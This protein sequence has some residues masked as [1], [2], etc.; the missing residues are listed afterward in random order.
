MTL[1][2]ALCI[3][4]GVTA[5]VGGG[6][7]TT[8]LRALGEELS[9]A[10]HTVLL[11]TTT[12]MYPFPGLRNLT[13]AGETELAAALAKHPLLC[14]GT[15]VPETGKLTAPDI[16]IAALAA[17]AEYVLA[18][19]DGAAG[20]PVKAHAAH[21]PV[22]PT[23]ANQ[24]ICVV[25]ASGFG[26]P[27]FLAAHRPELYAKRAGVGQ[28]ALITPEIEAAVL[29]AEG[30]HHR[31]YVNQAESPQ[32]LSA[33]KEL[34]KLLSSPVAAGALRSEGSQVLCW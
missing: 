11:C 27:V 14:V 21:E 7:K 23:E 18:E 25:G 2:D 4:P 15:P 10:G 12:K 28:D 1:T 30:L 13:R 29:L 24:V 3:R 33:A 19:A 9:R 34:Q 22:I 5:V 26:Q 17:L 16:P 32:R 8:L 31:V 6:G 20:R